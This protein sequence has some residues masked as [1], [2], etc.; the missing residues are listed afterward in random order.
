M[1]GRRRGSAAST[2]NGCATLDVIP[3]GFSKI[4]YDNKGEARCAV[5]LFMHILRVS[6]LGARVRA[7]ERA[8][9]C[10]HARRSRPRDARLTAL[11]SLFFF[12]SF[13]FP[14]HSLLP[15]RLLS[16]NINKRG[17]SRADHQAR[18]QSLLRGESF[19]LTGAGTPLSTTKAGLSGS[20]W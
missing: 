7:K 11:F 14:S 9:S 19:P 20:Y 3:A 8:G 2:S 10:I 5:L 13:L 4:S 6:I 12:P 18:G 16:P 15:A 17:Q 1:E